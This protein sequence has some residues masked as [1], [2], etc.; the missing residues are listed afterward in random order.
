[1]I[2]ILIKAV[3]WFTEILTFLIIA[4]AIMSWFVRDP[5]SSLFNIYQ[6]IIRITEPIVAPCRMLLARFNTGMMDFSILL[7]FLLISVARN[8]IVNILAM[9]L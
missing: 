3:N 9:L 1:M 6:T 5:S 2:L 8:V 4:R 7:A